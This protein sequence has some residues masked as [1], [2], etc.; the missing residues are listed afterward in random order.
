MV[1]ALHQV[2]VRRAVL[3]EAME[4]VLGVAANAVRAASNPVKVEKAAVAAKKHHLAVSLLAMQ[5]HL[6]ALR[7]VEHLVVS[8]RR[9]KAE[10]VIVRRLLYGKRKSKVRLSGR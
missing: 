6:E 7:K 4:V 3:A 10:R 9:T 2:V 5:Q 8:G 1:T